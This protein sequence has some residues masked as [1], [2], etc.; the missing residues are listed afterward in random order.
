MDQIF[1]SQNLIALATLVLLE[2]VLGIDNI[3]FIAI[4]SGKLPPQDR[5]RTRMLGIALAVISRIILLLF[6]NVIVHLKDPILPVPFREPL[7]GKE[8]LLLV[9][10]LFLIGKSTIEIYEKVEAHEHTKTN[11]KGKAA[12]SIAGV[13]V[14]VMLVDIIFSLDSVI[15]AVGISGVLWVM[16]TAIIL[17]AIVMIFFANVVSDFVDQH[18]TIKILALSFLIMIGLVLVMEGWNPEMAHSLH[19][20]N[21]VYFAMAFSLI[22]DLLQMRMKQPDPV[23][24]HN[25]PHMPETNQ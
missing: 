21:Y 18:P 16:I 24:L 23:S 7:S 20:K 1:T 14:Q 13:L 10:G 3:I 4:L 12:A 19:I 6:I 5:P 2:I 22:V 25:Q 17:A 8:I 15:T 9:G 11:S